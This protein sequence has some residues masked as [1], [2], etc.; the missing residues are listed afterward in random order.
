MDKKKIIILCV[1]LVLLVAA[2]VLLAVFMPNIKMGINARKYNLQKADI[3]VSADRIYFLNTGGS[4]AILIESDG[5]FAMVDAAE[6]NDN[7]RNFEGLKLTGYEDYVVDFVKKI[8]GDENGRVELEFV[9]GTHAHSDHIGGFD[10]LIFDEDITV[11]TAY[12]REYDEDRISEY[13]I[14]SWDNKEVYEQMLDACKKRGVP[15][16]SD[17]SAEPFTFGSFTMQFINTEINPVEGR[18]G[19]NENAVGLLIEKNGTKAFLSADINNYDGDEDRIAPAIG[20]VDLLK[21]GHHG[22]EGSST[23]NFINTLSPDI[24]VLTR[25]NATP[26]AEPLKNLNRVN[27]AIYATGK[28]GEIIAEFTENGIALFA[29]IAE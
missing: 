24:A 21:V 17:I 2:A 23:E 7:P 28:Y 26:S 1:I 12:L 22:H 3:S 5:K 10:T 19:E 27:A 13:E 18:V 6:D 11:K 16:V 9:L 4:D 14:E 25:G 15:V 29:G 8:A 20:K